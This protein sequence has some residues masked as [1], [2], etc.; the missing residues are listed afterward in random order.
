MCRLG[1]ELELVSKELLAVRH[2]RLKKYYDACYDECV[3]VNLGDPQENVGGDVRVLTCCVLMAESRW[4]EELRARG[5]AII[6][7]RD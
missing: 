3:T 1:E 4:E 5:L 7:D 2:D 6:R